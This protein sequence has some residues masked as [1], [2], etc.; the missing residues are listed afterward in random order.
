VKAL[1][2]DPGDTIAY[3]TTGA[4]TGATFATGSN[5]NKVFMFAPTTTGEHVVTFT[6]TDQ[7]AL[8]DSKTVSLIGVKSIDQC[9]AAVAALRDPSTGQQPDE[10]TITTGKPVA[11]TCFGD[12]EDAG[13]VCVTNRVVR[14]GKTVTLNGQNSYQ[15][16]ETVASK[17]TTTS[18]EDMIYH[19][20]Q[21]GTGG[22][23][24]ITLSDNNS[25]TASQPTFTAPDAPISSIVRCGF[26]LTV[27][28]DFGV[29][30]ATARAT[31]MILAD[32]SDEESPQV[33]FGIMAQTEDGI[34]VKDPPLTEDASI[35][36]MENG[37]YSLANADDYTL[38]S[39]VDT[40][41]LVT[42]MNNFTQVSRTA[43]FKL[44]VANARTFDVTANIANTGDAGTQEYVFSLP[45]FDNN[46]GAI[47][48]F[49]RGTLLT[50]GAN[51]VVNLLNDSGTYQ[52]DRLYGD[53]E[54]AYFGAG[55]KFLDFDEDGVDDIITKRYDAAT[56]SAYFVG[57][58]GGSRAGQSIIMNSG[59][60]SFQI[61]GPGMSLA[62]ASLGN[63]KIA[64]SNDEFGFSRGPSIELMI[65][66]KNTMS[67]DL[68]ND[69]IGNGGGVFERDALFNQLFE[70][71]RA[72]MASGFNELQPIKMGAQ[73]A[74]ENQPNYCP[75]G[76]QPPA[77][78]SS[79]YCNQGGAAGGNNSVSK[80]MSI[81]N[82][83]E[84][85]SAAASLIEA[86]DIPE[87][88][89]IATGDINHDGYLDT[90]V[91]DPDAAK[92]YVYYGNA[93][94][95]G[96]KDVADAD[97][98]ITCPLENSECGRV[99]VVGDLSGDGY[100]DIVIGA[101]TAYGQDGTIPYAGE[102]Y[103]IYGTT[104]LPSEIDIDTYDGENIIYGTAEN[105]YLGLEM[106]IIDSD[107]NGIKEL[108]CNLRSG[109][110]IIISFDVLQTLGR[111]L[112]VD[113]L[114]VTTLEYTD[115]AQVVMMKLKFSA[116]VDEDI[117]VNSFT[118]TSAGSGLD[119]VEVRQVQIYEDTNVDGTLD[120]GDRLIVGDSS[121]EY[122][123]GTL[124]FTN[125][126]ETVAR[127]AT[128]NWLIVYDFSKSASTGASQMTIAR[129]NHPAPWSIPAMMMGITLMIIII[130]RNKRFGIAAI[131]IF[132][133]CSQITGCRL[134]DPNEFTS[135]RSGTYIFQVSVAETA[136]ISAVGKSSGNAAE[137][138]GA[139]AAGPEITVTFTSS[140]SDQSYGGCG[141]DLDSRM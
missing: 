85:I 48:K 26:D 27:E 119:D 62:N 96:I 16:A 55:A 124:T 77:G 41:G 105:G 35:S 106:A 127:G 121:F 57:V 71:G 74:P 115:P 90:A 138:L 5:S 36:F 47:F 140:A 38:L 23:P 6:A 7:G 86:L 114:N 25:K 37:A 103:V 32:K 52:I 133:M 141:W 68:K 88:T 63:L 65:F 111:A 125:I 116:S 66:G 132:F 117:V 61:G 87:S 42:N 92:V 10:D 22:C 112:R 89:N 17:I 60:Y 13:G 136:H 72:F 59:A 56:A 70:I 3:T 24:S 30:E 81:D 33:S 126:G 79:N 123:N 91:G 109:G 1:D 46:R 50:H 29:S 118:V 43:S 100:D 28:N 67:I 45:K 31:V 20:T 15:P 69:I 130:R 18:T 40:N 75:P 99:I 14:S 139:P 128:V 83:G 95:T 80:S 78:Y 110:A 53:S 54:G 8:S 104:P 122:D 76:Y 4:P 21:T 101:P 94:F 135:E 64:M 84:E 34:L 97:V 98:V 58:P 107:G 2:T 51:K 73:A 134:D 93:S 113:Q 49:E 82:G 11:K 129:S 44:P 131:A 137:I 12:L 120:A 39:L 102:I 9:A 108:A 19:W